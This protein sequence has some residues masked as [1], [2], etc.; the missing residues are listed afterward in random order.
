MGV[1]SGVTRG[2]IS[3]LW[4][5]PVPPK[6]SSNPIKPISIS[7]FLTFF[8]LNSSLHLFFPPFLP[9]LLLSNT[10]ADLFDYTYRPRQ[11]L[12]PANWQ[13][14]VPTCLVGTGTVAH[15]T[16]WSSS[17]AA[18]WG[19]ITAK[20][21]NESNVESVIGQEGKRECCRESGVPMSNIWCW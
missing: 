6:P 18:P 16:T 2:A 5:T 7:H 4:T 11:P 19:G 21:V 3:S 8:L 14:I 9:L 15:F 10:T 12:H 1:R 17:W 20:H 13:T